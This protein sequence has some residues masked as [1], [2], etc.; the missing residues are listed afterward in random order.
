MVKIELLVILVILYL[1]FVPNKSSNLGKLSNLGSKVKSQI[2]SGMLVG[3]DLYDYRQNTGIPNENTMRN[4]YIQSGYNRLAERGNEYTSTPYGFEHKRVI[5]QLGSN[6]FL[7]YV[8]RKHDGKL[9]FNPKSTKYV[10]TFH[11]VGKNIK[12]GSRLSY[13]YPLNMASKLSTRF[14]DR[15]MNP[16]SNP[17]REEHLEMVT[18]LMAH[19]KPYSV[20]GYIPNPKS[21][22]GH[23]LNNSNEN[24][25][26]KFYDF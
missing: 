17:D 2:E 11:D 15:K 8:P 7:T 20:V 5:D 4:Q 18:N 25:Y 21:S 19:K 10:N 24:D 13:E 22:N 26:Y 6:N 23:C 16:I 9:G 14:Y 1:F 3:N 12:D